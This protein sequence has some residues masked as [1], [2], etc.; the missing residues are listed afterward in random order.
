[1]VGMEVMM[2][3]APRYSTSVDKQENHVQF[4]IQF[5]IRMCK[6]CDITFVSFTFAFASL[7]CCLWY[8]LQ[9]VRVH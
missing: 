7:L 2:G 5:E 3:A 1:M 9:M 8:F 4:H 6:M